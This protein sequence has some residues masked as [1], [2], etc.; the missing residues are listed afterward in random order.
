MYWQHESDRTLHA[1]VHF[2]TAPPAGTVP[3]QIFA[4]YGTVTFHTKVR[5]CT[6]EKKKNFQV[7]FHDSRSQ[8][9]GTRTVGI[10]T[11]AAILEFEIAARD[12]GVNGE[13]G[14]YR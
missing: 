8:S 6:S 12:G 13:A 7:L 9:T 10:P 5:V 2:L 1:V 3:V 14:Y 4:I 11:F